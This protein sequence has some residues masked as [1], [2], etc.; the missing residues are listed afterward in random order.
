MRLLA[1]D[2][3]ARGKIVVMLACLDD[4]HLPRLA[5]RPYNA[6]FRYC[7][8]TDAGGIIQLRHSLPSFPF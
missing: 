2:V 4:R 6:L 5:G 3:C 8:S 7:E 1:L